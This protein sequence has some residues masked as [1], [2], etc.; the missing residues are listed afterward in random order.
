MI[1]NTQD[2]GRCRVHGAHI[3]GRIMVLV[4]CSGLGALVDVGKCRKERKREVHNIMASQK[5][6]TAKNRKNGAKDYNC[7]NKFK[8][9]I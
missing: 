3:S 9:C 6:T 2:A 7:K 4:C 8:K 1:I 5:C